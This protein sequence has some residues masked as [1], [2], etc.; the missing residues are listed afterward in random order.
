MHIQ[1]MAD[2]MNTAF[3]HEADMEEETEGGCQT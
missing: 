1:R 3:G 2:E